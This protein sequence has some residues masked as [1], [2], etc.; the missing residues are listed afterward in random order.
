MLQQQGMKHKRENDL[1]NT[2]EDVGG[3]KWKP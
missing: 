2:R 3:T 1:C